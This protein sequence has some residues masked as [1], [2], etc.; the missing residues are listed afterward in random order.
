[1]A[2]PTEKQFEKLKMLIGHIVLTPGFRE[3]QPF[4]K[5]GWVGAAWGHKLEPIVKG[6]YKSWPP[7]RLTA[8]G[9]RALADAIDRYGWAAENHV[10]RSRPMPERTEYRVVTKM[11]EGEFASPPLLSEEGAKRLLF[12]RR[13]VL[14]PT[15]WSRL[16]CRTLAETPWVDLLSPSKGSIVAEKRCIGHGVREGNCERIITAEA[17]HLNASGLWC[18]ECEEARRKHIS[19]QFAAIKESLGESNQDGGE[20]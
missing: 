9:Y 4:V 13:E 19:A 15:Y 14:Y 8:D 2:V 1:V 12:N 17:L 18:V 7:L 11:P 3:W 20:S 10:R 5:R 6:R 16:E